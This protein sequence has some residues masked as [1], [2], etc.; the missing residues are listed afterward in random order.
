[1]TA[2]L[3][4][5]VMHYSDKMK[6]TSFNK[7]RGIYVTERRSG[8]PLSEVLKPERRSLTFFLASM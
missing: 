7:I 3:S 6:Q 1:M 5:F 4:W 8:S 2:P